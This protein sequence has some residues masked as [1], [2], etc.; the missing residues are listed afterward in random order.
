MSKR[1]AILPRQRVPICAQFQVERKKVVCAGGGVKVCCT[2]ARQAQQFIVVEEIPMEYVTVYVI[3]KHSADGSSIAGDRESAKVS[4]PLSQNSLFHPRAFGCSGIC[5]LGDLS[6]Q[7]RSLGAHIRSRKRVHH[8][9]PGCGY[10]CFLAANRDS[11]Q[12]VLDRK[13]TRL[14]SSHL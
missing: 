14:N 12:A 10:I 4:D 2:G 7:T 9:R 8:E 6:R 5:S 1:I 11:R 3:Q 13:S